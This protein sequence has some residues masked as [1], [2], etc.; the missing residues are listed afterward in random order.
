MI[1]YDF[2]NVER[3]P[4]IGNSLRIMSLLDLAVS[5]F[6]I[7]FL[8][9]VTLIPHGLKSKVSLPVAAFLLYI[10]RLTYF[11]ENVILVHAAVVYGILDSLTPI[12]IVAGAVFLFETMDKTKCMSWILNQLANLSKGQ[13]IAEIMLIGW[14]FTYV[15]EGASG[16]GTPTALAAPIL[17]NLGI[18]PMN[19]VLVCLV[20]NTLQTPF[21]AVGTPIWFGLGSVLPEDADRLQLAMQA[22][23]I[24]LISA[25]FV[26]FFAIWLAL[27]N[28][29]SLWN[30]KIFIMISLLSPIVP[31]LLVSL[32]SFE[33]PTIVGGVIGL[34]ITAVCVR[35]RIGLRSEPETSHEM[36][37]VKV[38]QEASEIAAE[39]INIKDAVLSTFPIWGVVVILVL[40]RIPQIGLRRVLTLKEPAL[41]ASLGSLGEFKISASLVLQLNKIFGMQNVNWTYSTL[42]IPAWLPFV[43]VSVLTFVIHRNKMESAFG[44]FKLVCKTVAKRMEDPAVALVG[45]T[46]LVALMTTKMIGES[47]QRAP[48]EVIGTTIAS[49]LRH[50][51]IAIA[52]L[53]G[54]LGS[55]FSGSTT[56]SNLTFGQVQKTVAE[57]INVNPIGMLTLQTVGGSVGNM[58]CIHNI[59]SAKAVV[60]LMEIPEGVFIKRMLLAF[61][62]FIV[63]G[64]LSGLPFLFR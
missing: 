53:I 52:M 32:F 25:F 33:L 2:K 50:G 20:F 7:L 8:L 18:E 43:V 4:L 3:R 21:G 49:G 54:A 41:Q 5:I 35:Y 59:L 58:I 23:I 37:D 9:T 17:A 29:R 51:W 36:E 11:Q 42:F 19:A 55:F 12:S 14:T 40:T 16:F 34:I 27:P 60:G 28:W 39:P 44:D 62:I 10:I 15:V 46:A 1:H 45:A 57:N 61:S 48:A 56:I 26:S 13:K 63:V 22:Q 31:A 30:D 38:P 24:L 47:T 6:P 64:T